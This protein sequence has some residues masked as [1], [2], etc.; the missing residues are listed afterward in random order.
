MNKANALFVV[1]GLSLSLAS[2]SF[3]QAPSQS[4]VDV[5]HVMS[6]AEF[7]AA[8]LH[9]LSDAEI[10]SLNNWL[11]GFFAKVILATTNPAPTDAVIESQIDGAFEGWDG[12]TIFK[13]T[14]GQIW[15]Q[16]SYAYH[17]HYAF[18][19]EVVIYKTSGGYKM[20][21]DDVDETIYVRRI[22]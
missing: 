5:R 17:Y 13:L 4:P 16:S 22:K 21:V 14:N 11:S 12:E 1:A 9:R 20:K 18:M 7:Q 6:A 10:T 2:E 15:Q 3:S 8:G 19:P